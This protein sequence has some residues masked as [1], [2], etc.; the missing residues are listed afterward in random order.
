ME[1]KDSTTVING[2]YKSRIEA[3][4]SSVLFRRESPVLDL[5]VTLGIVFTFSFL[6]CIFANRKLQPFIIIRYGQFE[7]V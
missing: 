4:D 6:Y 5:I 2:I 1:R 3:D 7:L